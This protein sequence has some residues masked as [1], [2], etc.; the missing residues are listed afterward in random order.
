MDLQ[1]NKPVAIPEEWKIAAESLSS[2]MP[3]GEADSLDCNLHDKNIKWFRYED[4]IGT[5]MSDAEKAEY[6]QAVEEQLKLGILK[7]SQVKRTGQSQPLP[8]LGKKKIGPNDPC[9]CG[10]G[11]KAKVC[12][13]RNNL[14]P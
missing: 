8:N 13:F 12:H 3:A 5:E 4:K 7:P 10:S 14:R 11:R 6:R 2:E 9:P 1:E